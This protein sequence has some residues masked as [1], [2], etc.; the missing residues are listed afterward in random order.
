MELARENGR[1]DVCALPYGIN[2]VRCFESKRPTCF[3]N[4]PQSKTIFP[5]TKY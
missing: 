3:N 5:Q 1:T 4:S 2:T